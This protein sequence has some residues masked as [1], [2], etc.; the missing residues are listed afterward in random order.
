MSSQQGMQERGA[1]EWRERGRGREEE[2]GDLEGREAIATARKYNERHSSSHEEQRHYGHQVGVAADALGALL[3]SNAVGPLKRRARLRWHASARQAKGGGTR[4]AELGWRRPVVEA[5]VRHKQPL[6]ARRRIEGFDGHP[7]ERVVGQVELLHPPEG[8]RA[9]RVGHVATTKH[10]SHAI[11]RQVN[12]RNQALPRRL[13][14]K[15]VGPLLRPPPFR[16]GA[17]ATV[18]ANGNW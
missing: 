10:P 13:S 18:A 6:Q 8:A 1:G 9:E 5:V 11:A 7:H 4:E 14:A 3:E 12:V 2:E 17:I 16:G 15:R